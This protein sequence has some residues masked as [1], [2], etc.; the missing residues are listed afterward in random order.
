MV[1][2]AQDLGYSDQAHFIHDFKAFTSY[3]PGQKA[4]Q[5]L[6]TVPTAQPKSS[7]TPQQA[8]AYYGLS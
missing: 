8:A 3:T 7:L 5:I 6:T 2:L 1:E 4:A